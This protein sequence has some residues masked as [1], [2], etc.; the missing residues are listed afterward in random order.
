MSAKECQGVYQTVYPA[1]PA[2]ALHE[3][4]DPAKRD[5]L[6]PRRVV[7]VVRGQAPNKKLLAKI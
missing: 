7:S 1:D 4:E 6:R 3:S 5:K 2:Y